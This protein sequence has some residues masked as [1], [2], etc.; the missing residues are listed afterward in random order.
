MNRAETIAS[1]NRFIRPAAF[2]VPQFLVRSS[3]LDHG[4]FAF[5]LMDI[6]RPESLVEL[7]THNGYSYFAFCEAVKRLGL[8]TRC[9]AVDTWEGDEHAGRYTEHVFQMVDRHNE[10]NYTQFS[11]L[12]RATFDDAVSHFPDGSIDLLHIDGRHFY[13]DVKHDFE[14]WIPK[15]SDR[16]VVLF[17]DINVRERGFGCYKLWDEISTKSPSFAFHHGHGLGVLGYG[18]ALPPEMAKFFATTQ[19]PAVADELRNAFSRLGSSIKAQQ[20]AGEQ[21]DYIHKLLTMIDEFREDGVK[22]RARIDG[23]E[24]VVSGHQAREQDLYAQVIAASRHSEDLQ[25]LLTAANMRSDETSRAAREA[26]QIAA[27]Q[28]AHL[29]QLLNDL[30]R[31]LSWRITAPLRNVRRWQIE[32]KPLLKTRIRKTL[33]AIYHAIPIPLRHKRRAVN[34]LVGLWTGKSPV[35]LKPVALPADSDY[36]AAVPFAYTPATAFAGRVAVVVHVYYEDLTAEVARYLRNIPVPF[37]TFICTDT[38][39]KRAGILG[40]FANWD[41][42]SVQVRLVPNRGRDIAP[43]LLAFRDIYDSYEFVLH[44]HTKSSSTADHL[45][46]FRNWRGFIFENLL[47]SPEIVASILET[48]ARHRDVGMIAAQHFE[49]IRR[50]LNWGDNFAIAQGLAARMGLALSDERVLDFPSGSMFWAR[51]AALKPLLDLDLR[52]TDFPAEA[53]QLDGT[54]AHAIERMFFFS[55]EAAKLKW[56]KV[57]NPPLFNDLQTIVTIDSTAALDT[58]VDKRTIALTGP[59]PPAPVLVQPPPPRGLS[60]AL[61]ARLQNSA[62]NAPKVTPPE[63]ARPID[64]DFSAVVPFAYDPNPPAP[65]LAAIC[66]VYY[67]TMAVEFQRYLRNIPFDFDVFISTDLPGKKEIIDASFAGWDKGAVEVRVVPNRGR[68]IAPKLIGFADV[69]PRYDY[70]LHLHSKASE[71]ADV[72]ANWRGYILE[73]MLGSPAIV[74]SVFE[75]FSRHPEVGMVA[76]QHFEPVRHWVNWGGNFPMAKSLADRMGIELKPERALDFPSGSMFW[77]RTAALKPLLDLNLTLDDFVDENGQVDATPAHAIERLYF[78]VCDAAGYRWLKIANPA[79]FAATPAMVYIA[80]PED[81]DRFVTQ[82]TLAINSPAF[83]PPRKELPTPIERPVPELV[84]RL[85]ARAMGSREPV[86]T[87]TKVVVGIVTYSN[88]PDQ[89]R[90]VVASAITALARAGLTA[91][92]RI[93]LLDN[94][95]ATSEAVGSDPAIG[96]LPTAGNVGFGAGHNRLMKDAFAK[97]ADIYIATNPDGLLEPEAI[98]A[99]VQMMRAYNGRALIEALQFPDEH[100]KVYDPYTL[101]TPWVS[102]ACLAFSRAAYEALGGFDETFFMYGED[103]DVSWRARAH[104]FALRVC[105]R[106]LFLHGV[107]NRPRNPESLKMIYQSMAILGTKWGGAAFAADAVNELKALGA[108][109]PQAK[110]TPVPESWRRIAD[111]S[112]KNAFAATRW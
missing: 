58:F 57:A 109:P 50:H 81:L 40:V 5:A 89:M 93:C 48:F 53:G 29:T 78:H 45:E 39:G 66:H 100:P 6:L 7:G 103:V 60:T 75:T 71:H 59:N 33:R 64:L 20:V 27:R 90:R 26:D 41:R 80:A 94:G 1:A 3:W 84:A 54:L 11:R 25:V 77:A 49:P 22:V 88:A 12:V 28:I 101:E 111:F 38:P 44:L 106:A 67:E 31:S 15:L 108:P 68:D 55:C 110:P 105:P 97:G 30:Q 34:A 87:Q 4:P 16:A 24:K 85:Q 112:H 82:H 79:L 42:G 56:L 107:T 21:A 17:H 2:I 9:Y 61:I 76:C 70:V 18:K 99:L 104:G 35:L 19:D 36:S 46:V 95:A 8:G 91:N 98:G 47:G 52:V 69:Y 13:E 37:D 32:K 74:R 92:G 43:K 63:S 14:T 83:P 102:G 73:N 10:A 96:Y 62:H 65:R 72:L 51:S 23:L 86:D